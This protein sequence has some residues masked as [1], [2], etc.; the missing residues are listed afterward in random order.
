[1]AAHG[2][3]FAKWTP[4]KR[5]SIAFLKVTWHLAASHKQAYKILHKVCNDPQ[6][7][8]GQSIIGYYPSRAHYPLDRLLSILT[9]WLWNYLFL[10]ITKKYVDFI[11]VQY[12]FSQGK[13][14]SLFP[15]FIG[16]GN[17][18]NLPVSDMSWSI[19]PDA[20]GKELKRVY[21]RYGIPLYVTENGVADAKDAMRGVF[22][23]DHIQAMKDARTAGVDIRGYFYWSLLDNFE[24]T[25]GFDSQFGLIHVDRITKKR[26]PRSSAYV[27]QRIIEEG[28]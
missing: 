2:W 13:K 15:P 22:I 23:H 26:T 25:E 9:R 20:F 17:T 16:S 24:W 21:A 11:G 8:I 1:Y 19:D 12:Y 27:Y 7:G 18:K 10:D 4:Q 14:F 6:V 5:D 3:L 28:L